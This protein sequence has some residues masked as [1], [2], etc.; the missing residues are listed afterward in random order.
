MPYCMHYDRDIQVK[1]I[2]PPQCSLLD[3]SITDAV[4]H[5]TIVGN[6]KVSGVAYSMV[7]ADVL[8]A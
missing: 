4:A 2:V 3:Y 1:D 6:Y 5:C 8:R 7:R